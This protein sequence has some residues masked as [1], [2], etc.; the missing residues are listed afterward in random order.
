MTFYFNKVQA[1]FLSDSGAE[2]FEQAVS[3]KIPDEARKLKRAKTEVAF[4]RKLISSFPSANQKSQ[5]LP[6]FLASK[7]GMFKEPLSKTSEPSGKAPDF[8]H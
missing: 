3:A 1:S 2:A 8:G 7:S 6:E 5:P 4:T